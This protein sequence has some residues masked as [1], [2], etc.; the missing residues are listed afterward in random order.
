MFGLML[1]PAGTPTSHAP[2]APEPAPASL[3]GAGRW[4]IVIDD[5]PEICA[6]MRALLQNWN[7]HVLSA[8]SQTELTSQLI[9]LP[10]VPALIISDHG[11]GDGPTGIDVIES[12]HDEYNR[13]IPAL[14]ITGNTAPERLREA[15]AS[16]HRLLHKPVSPR[17]LRLAI[18]ELLSAPQP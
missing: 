4:V 14:L 3:D 18:H 17:Q 5:E 1:A 15:A 6:G 8:C 13:E 10:E 12:L 16:G 11:L 7:F 9:G 2:A